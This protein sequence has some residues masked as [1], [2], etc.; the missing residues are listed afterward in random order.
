MNTVQNMKGY[1]GNDKMMT[2]GI[3]VTYTM[4]LGYE[5]FNSFQILHKLPIKLK[6]L[7]ESFAW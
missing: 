5:P 7:E 4:A 1:N 6:T 3:R 2:E